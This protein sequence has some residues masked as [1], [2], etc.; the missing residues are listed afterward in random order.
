MS[1]DSADP[2]PISVR[3][4]NGIRSATLHLGPDGARAV[5]WLVLQTTGLGS[6]VLRPDSLN[7]TSRMF[8]GITVTVRCGAKGC[9]GTIFSKQLW[10]SNYAW[11]RPGPLPP[12]E[13]QTFGL[14]LLQA[15]QIATPGT[16]PHEWTEG[17]P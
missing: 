9:M 14:A 13:V 5:R 15:A 4:W 10:G 16:W 7:G 11:V 2:Q 8:L 6:S 1:R 12:A 17:V 3:A